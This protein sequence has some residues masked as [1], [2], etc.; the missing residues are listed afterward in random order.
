LEAIDGRCERNKKLLILAAAVECRD[1][2]TEIYTGDLNAKNISQQ[3]IGINR[4]KDIAN[5][6]KI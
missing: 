6:I 3:T 4:I 2:S 5:A 1:V